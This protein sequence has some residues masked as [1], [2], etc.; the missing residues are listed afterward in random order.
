MKSNKQRRAELREIRAK[1]KEKLIPLKQDQSLK[2]IPVNAAHCNPEALA[3]SIS[4]YTVLPFVDDQGYYTDLPFQCRDCQK[5]E[6]WTAPQQKWWYEVAKGN[7][8][9]FAV[10]CRAC[11][12][13][14]RDR[15]IEARRV[16]LE[17]L[18]KKRSLKNLQ[19]QGHN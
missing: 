2:K 8:L 5:Q 17:G 15:K 19:G 3:P 14:E 11:R 6:I 1:R 13:I 12:Q 18:A 16:H 4:R 9:S 10:R 7:I